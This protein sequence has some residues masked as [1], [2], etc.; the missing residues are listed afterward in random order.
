MV[1]VSL[2]GILLL[3]ACGSLSMEGKWNGQD[4]DGNG[5]ILTFKEDSVLVDIGLKTSYSYKL[6]KDESAITFKNGREETT[7]R[8]SKKDND[9]ITLYNKKKDETLELER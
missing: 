6:N 1:G 5:A 9:H 2:L 7:Y 8:L 3:T 4:Q